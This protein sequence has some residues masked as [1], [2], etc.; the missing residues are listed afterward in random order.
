MDVVELYVKQPVSLVWDAGYVAVNN[1]TSHAWRTLR[2]SSSVVGFQG[3]R[4]EV[5]SRDSPTQL[6]GVL[7]EDPFFGGSA[8][9]LF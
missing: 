1:Y 3:Q 5:T 9:L 7:C 4:S 2:P 8:R 6:K